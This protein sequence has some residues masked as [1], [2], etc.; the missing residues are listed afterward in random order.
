MG[1]K[2]VNK[3]AQNIQHIHMDIIEFPLSSQHINMDA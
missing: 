2:D 3:F 1:I